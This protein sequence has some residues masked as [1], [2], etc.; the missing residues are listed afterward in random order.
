MGLA[1]VKE[2]EYRVDII[3]A[4]IRSAGWKPKCIELL[5]S[6]RHE[7]WRAT[8]EECPDLIFKCGQAHIWWPYDNTIEI[9]NEI[10][11][12]R[13]LQTVAPELVM[14][15]LA[16]GMLPT[17]EQYYIRRFV[18][19][20]LDQCSEKEKLSL[21]RRLVKVTQQLSSPDFRD[22]MLRCLHIPKEDLDLEIVYLLRALDE[23]AL[24][25]QIRWDILKQVRVMYEELQN[26]FEEGDNS[27]CI[28]IGN[29][30]LHNIAIMPNG[31]L[32]LID[33]SVFRTGSALHDL[34]KLHTYGRLECK[35]IDRRT[36]FLK[37]I[38]EH[39][40]YI[41][42]DLGVGVGFV[43]LLRLRHLLSWLRRKSNVSTTQ[44]DTERIIYEK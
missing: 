8:V 7:V 14:P 10:K 3:E 37:S 33:C 42:S 32:K 40:K 34:V 39:V 18:E 11:T 41:A 16:S 21:V 28:V 6:G 29:F 9:V 27:Q 38:N 30:S 43:R 23:K 5:E 26:G 44:S 19:R 36:P 20:V 17:G 4:T 15:V 35:E 2:Q 25:K 12:T 1:L 24:K 31:S 22:K 13:V